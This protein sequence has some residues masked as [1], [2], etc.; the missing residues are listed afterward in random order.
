[1]GPEI[2][3][4]N[5]INLQS[6]TI[7]VTQ[8]DDI[9]VLEGKHPNSRAIDGLIWLVNFM[10]QRGKGLNANAAIITGSFKGIVNMAFDIETTISY[11]GIADYTV[12]FQRA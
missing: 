11:Q 4:T 3:K 8:G 2:D 1:V 7:N 9:R 5:A 10:S 6:T 12:T